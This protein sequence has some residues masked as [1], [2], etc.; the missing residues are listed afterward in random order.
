MPKI[1]WW[2]M[3]ASFLITFREALEATLI[4]SI[5]LAYLG[6]V[7]RRDLRKYLYLGTGSA[8][9]ISV[10]LGWLI[11]AI[12]GG[13]PAGTDKLFEGFASISATI[14]LT[15]MIF[16]MAHNSQNIRRELQEKIDLAITSGYV[17]GISSL[18]FV[19]VF[20]EG[21][22]T[23]LFLTSLATAD[24]LGTITGVLVG[25]STVLAIAFLMVKGAYRLNIQKFFKY[26]SVILVVFAAGLF[27]YGVH[28]LIEADILPPIVEHVWDIN[29]PDVTH[30]F[31]EN[32]AIGSILKALVGYDGNPELLRVIVYVGY[33]L[34]IGSYLLKIYAPNILRLNQK[35]SSIKGTR[36]ELEQKV[37]N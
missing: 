32:G 10:L 24:L 12:Y 6:R 36:E 1:Q 15:Y 30:P 33:W 13:L 35:R 19:S 3:I 17:L 2:R 27:G 20:R 23:V 37:T 11:I 25:L 29:P 14:V 4:V 34:V 8:V 9:L 7:R 28:E 16:W 22:E 26:T 18:A 5:L 31:H 21:L